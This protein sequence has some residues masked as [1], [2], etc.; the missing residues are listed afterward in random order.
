MTTKLNIQSLAAAD[1]AVF[2][3]MCLEFCK[4]CVTLQPNHNT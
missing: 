2:L 1:A 4:K 3:P